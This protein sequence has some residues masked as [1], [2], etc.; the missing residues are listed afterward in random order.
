MVLMSGF[1]V[2]PCLAVILLRKK[3]ADCLSGCMGSVSLPR[4]AGGW[5]NVCDCCISWS[6]SLFFRSHVHTNVN[7]SNETNTNN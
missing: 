3:K 1:G 5:S 7:D 6:Y 2:L 4:G